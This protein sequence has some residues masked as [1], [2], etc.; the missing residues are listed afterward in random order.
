[1]QAVFNNLLKNPMLAQS[2]AAGAAAAANLPPPCVPQ[3]GITSSGH[4]LIP[5][6]S[7]S[8]VPP[9]GGDDNGFIF[10]EKIF[11]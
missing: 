9:T 8:S 11:F 1:M 2:A 10:F 5:G 4:P 7:S 6:P 3:P